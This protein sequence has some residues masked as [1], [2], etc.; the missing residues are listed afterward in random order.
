METDK[1]NAMRGVLA[2]VY[3]FMIALLLLSNCRGCDNESTRSPGQEPVGDEERAREVGHHGQIKVTALWDFAGDVDLHVTEPDGTEIWF[4]NMKHRSTGGELD[5][6]NIP[7][8]QGSAENIYFTNPL[9]G[10]Y[11]VE[12]VM[13]NMS[14]EAPTGGMV[15]V[16]IEV[17][18]QQETVP[19]RLSRQ[20]QRV[21]VKRFRY[22]N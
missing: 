20:S 3:A 1:K 8:G 10:E 11:L 15:R 16:V 6:D 19:I 14:S 17:D 4:R 9:D 5:V 21:T 7:G 22:H 18:G 13:Y 2:G 12:L